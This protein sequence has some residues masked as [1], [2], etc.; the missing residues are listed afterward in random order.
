MGTTGT[1]WALLG[2]HGHYWD[3]MGRAKIQYLNHRHYRASP[4]D[5]QE[6]GKIFICA[7]FQPDENI[8]IFWERCP[9]TLSPTGNAA[10]DPTGLGGPWTSAFGDITSKKLVKI[11]LLVLYLQSVWKLEFYEYD[12]ELA[13]EWGEWPRRLSTHGLCEPMKHPELPLSVSD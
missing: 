11:P 1:P 5:H 3:S 9:L 6:F 4:V 10:P 12:V 8:N 2:L 13:L 7:D